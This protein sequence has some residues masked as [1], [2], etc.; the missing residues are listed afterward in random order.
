MV[1]KGEINRTELARRNAE[2]RIWFP[3]CCGARIQGA[4][5]ANRQLIRNYKA[6]IL[7]SIRC[8]PYLWALDRVACEP[9]SQHAVDSV[10]S[11]LV[12]TKMQ[13]GN[14]YFG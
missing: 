8:E 1:S 4:V 14:Y 12:G 10:A 7:G 6:R 5:L 9:A 13:T 11:Y 2:V 3:F